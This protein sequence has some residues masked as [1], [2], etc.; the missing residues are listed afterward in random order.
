[1]V[2]LYNSLKLITCTFMLIAGIGSIAHGQAILSENFD[3]GTSAGDLTAVSGGNWSAHSGAGTGPIAYTNTSLSLTDY[4]ASGIG[5]SISITGSNSEDINRSFTTQTSGTVYF[6]AL[7]NISAVGTGNY[8]FHLNSS[9]FRARVGAKDDGSGGINFGIGASSSTLSYGTNSY[10]LNTDYLLVAS[11]NIDTGESNLY[12]LTTAE[13][14]EPGS[15]ETSDTGTSGTSI[16]A[17]SFRQS[18]NVPTANIDGVRVATS[19][20][21]I[22][23]DPAN[24]LVSFSSSTATVN[25]G[26]GTYNLSLSIQNPDGSSA[27]TVEVALTAGSDAD[28]DTYTTETVTFAAGSSADETVTLT[29]T[30]DATY[31]GQETLTFTLQNPAGGNSAALG[32]QSTFD[33]VIEDNDPLDPVT[34]PYAETFDSDLSGVLTFSVAGDTKEWYHNGSAAVAN[35]YSSGELEEDWLILPAINLDN[36]TN[37]FISFDSEYNYG[38]DDDADN[39]FKLV[40]STDYSG[41]GDPSSATWNELTFT[42]PSATETVTGSGNV[43]LSAISG[44]S[45]YLAFQYKYQSGN[46]RTWTIDNIAVEETTANLNV[47]AS[48]TDFGSVDNSN[49]SASQSFTVEGSGLTDDI[50]ITAPTN[51][52]VSLDDASFSSSETLTQSGG[53]VS[54]TTVYVR[55]SPTSGANGVKSGDVTISTTGASSETIAVTGTET[56]GVDILYSE[57]F[58]SCAIGSFNT[59]NITGAEVW[60]CTGNGQTGDGARMNG[61]DGG[62]KENEDWLIT[63]SIDLSSA[64]NATLTFYSDVAYPSE[65][66]TFEVFVSTDYTGSGDPTS[67]T[68]DEL[69]PDLDTDSGF[70]TWTSSGDLDLS[71]YIGGSVYI[72]FKYAST[73]AGAA[74]WTIDNIL[75]E[76]REP[77]LAD[78]LVDVSSFNSNF[79]F[80]EFGSSS[81]I[82]SYTVEG[83]NLSDD[84]TITPPNGFEIST[85]SDLSSNVGTNSSPLILSQ[86]GGVISSTTIYV[87]FTPDVADGSTDS[88]DIAHTSTGAPDVNISV[89]GAEGIAPESNI[90]ITELADPDNNAGL[91][92]IELYNAGDTE[93]DFSELSG[94]R[95]DKYTNA[96]TTVSQTLTLT[97]TIP[98]KGFYIIATGEADAD[99]ETAYG[100]APDQFDGADNDVAGSNGDD[101]LELYDG[102]GTLVDQFGVPGEDGT[103]TNHEFE[104]GRAER[105]IT[106]TSGNPVWDVSEWNI[107][108]DGS[109]FPGNGPQDAPEAFDPREWAGT[110]EPIITVD[111]SSFN[112]NFGFVEFGTDSDVKSYTVEGS[113]LTSDV[114]IT[115]PVGFELA[116]SSDFSSTIGTNA[117]P[118]T[119]AQSGG[120]L[121]ST[122][123]FVRFVPDAADG[124]TDSGDII[125]SST[126]ATDKAVAVEG[127]EGAS[128]ITDIS[129]ARGLTE[130]TEVT[131]SGIVTTPDYGF[132]NGQYYIQDNTGGINIFHPGN[133]GL[134]NSGDE[135]EIT[136]EIAIFND[137]IELEPSL[138][139]VL[140]SGNELPEAISI[141]ESGLD[142]AS[143]NQGMRVIIEGVSL[144]DETQWPTAAI[145]AGSNL[146]VDAQSGSTAFQITI[147]RGESFYDGSEV[148]G[149]P[150]TLTGILT[151]DGS[152]V[153]ILPF[154]DGDIVESD[155]ATGIIVDQSSFNSD[156]GLVEINTES[157]ISSYTVS[158]TELTDDL[159]ITVSGEFEISLTDDFS[160]NV[161]DASTPLTLSQTFGEI[162]TTEIFVRFVPTA[163]GAATGSITHSS[164]GITDVVVDL[165]GEGT[166]DN[167]TAIDPQLDK[168]IS[169]YP[170]P[171]EGGEL[172]IELSNEIGEVEVKLLSLRGNTIQSKMMEGTTTLNTSALKAGVYIIQLTNDDFNKNY[173]VIIK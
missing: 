2:K 25:E 95:I 97:G 91:R 60:S 125:H 122:E 7:V 56:G 171:V 158:A 101:N 147:D 117:S 151:R 36:Y 128:T 8:F 148:P 104:D 39:F 111:A 13:T 34:L 31:E 157:T 130:G 120:T 79:G 86:S 114:I 129:V 30:D 121:A 164:T 106:V 173:R 136:G 170:V 108:N 124:T 70:D 9:S 17:I 32:S 42:K 172:T 84:I 19:W 90:F 162:E 35:G 71:S 168:S 66:T 155:P 23:S 73:T 41:T 77:L 45:V 87:R 156:F 115:P 142:V 154:F 3:Y 40:Y 62:A 27:T 126:D 64:T 85:S 11:Y 68:W 100:T 67:A 15:P 24:T 33:L 74:Q 139:T 37:E 43:D 113:N 54:T 98:A 163:T 83:A 93:V 55:F 47:V 80:I 49:S 133:Q 107:D 92:Y 140:S 44:T 21:D 58:T 89:I 112:G 72:A 38:V 61:Y 132:N 138:V 88:G 135:V 50:T 53:T 145:D 152:D 46:W 14:T 29:L 48:I 127:T 109:T 110:G 28:I 166:E 26:D 94:W 6:S 160:A 119:L 81:D 159:T 75:V 131:I 4:A 146:D 105:K 78:I 99:F 143:A 10:S 22:I 167:V 134:V 5:G 116:T 123:I 150:F 144:T 103:D 161:G 51:F 20:S 96:S 153:Q 102:T 63:P 149:Q 82:R 165:S 137:L 16:S 69:T 118:L 141:S 52:E 65:E 57:E 76:D 12:V 18:S 1:M 59:Q 169:M